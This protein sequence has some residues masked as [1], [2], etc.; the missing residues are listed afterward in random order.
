MT[1]EQPLEIDLLLAQRLAAGVDPIVHAYRSGDHQDTDAKALAAPE[2]L[3]ALMPARDVQSITDLPTP[4][5]VDGHL[6]ALSEVLC[7]TRARF[8]AALH[9]PLYIVPPMAERLGSSVSVRLQWLLLCWISEA[10]WQALHSTDVGMQVPLTD[11]EADLLR[12]LAA[13]QRFLVLAEA[14]RGDRPTGQ[15][16]P[17]DDADRVFGAQSTHLFLARAA[18]ARWEWTGILHRHQSH[19]LLAAATSSQLEAELDQLLFD[20]PGSGPPLSV[21]SNRLR[22]RQRGNDPVGYSADDDQ[23]ITA[24]VEHHLLPRYRW[25]AA[26]RSSWALTRYPRWAK[27]ITT[28]IFVLCAVVVGLIGASALWPTLFGHSTLGTAAALVCLT[29]LAGAVGV[30]VHGR[31]WAW[32]WL[33]RVPA[34]AAIGLFMVTTM[35]PSWW[36]AAFRQ[37]GMSLPPDT[38]PPPVQPQWVALGFAVAA[39]AYLI[40]NARNTGLSTS[41]ALGRAIGVWALAALHALFVALCG[42]AWA[43]PVFSEDG[44]VFRA[45]WTDYPQAALVCLAQAGSWCLAAGVFSQMLWDGRPL[46]APLTHTH[47]RDER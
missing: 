29:Y 9:H 34:A 7:R 30:A 20:H 38:P 4:E 15:R 32:P 33:L 1:T 40:V 11:T 5:Q 28:I 2:V 37:A 42:I 36:H 26:R 3:Q 19:P 44:T 12:P 39:L 41:A 22:Q 35:H 45:A 17:Q 16:G 47:W 6:A 27:T 46:T 8:T 23:T 18:Q 13:R 24:L 21:S 43:V 31:S 14:F 10:T 25:G